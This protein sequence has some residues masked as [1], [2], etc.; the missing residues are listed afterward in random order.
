MRETPFGETGLQAVGPWLAAQVSKTMVPQVGFLVFSLGNSLFHEIFCFPL[1]R[2]FYPPN[3]VFVQKQAS[4]F[5]VRE[6]AICPGRERFWGGKHHFGPPKSWRR[7]RSNKSAKKGLT[8]TGRQGSSFFHPKIPNPV[9]KKPICG[10]WDCGW[11][12]R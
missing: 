3:C 5:P 9:F 6:R 2:G 4:V 11:R 1:S 8:T 7:P 10:L 12:R